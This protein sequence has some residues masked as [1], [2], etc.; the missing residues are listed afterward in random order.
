MTLDA[1]HDIDLVPSGYGRLNR[2]TR[3]I[4]DEA[5]RRDITVEIRDAAR[6]ELV[7]TCAG[8]T[9]TTLESLSEL[10]SA[11]AFRRCDDKRHTRAI[12]ECAGIAVPRG[13]S[14]TFDQRDEG[15]LH[16]RGELVVKPARGEQGWGITVGIRDV[17]HLQRAIASAAAVCPDVLLEERCG[18][19]DLRVIVIGDEVVAAA[20]RRP[21]MVLG[22]GDH[23][24]EELIELE[25]ERRSLATGGSARVPIDPMTL[26]AVRAGGYDLD[27]VLPRDVELMI[28]F[29][30][31]VHSGGTIHDVTDELHPT[32]CEVAIRAAHAIEIPVVGLDLLVG[33]VT[34][35]EYVMIEANEQPGLA[36]HEPRPTAAR[37]IDLLFPETRATR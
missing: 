28:R 11:V 35:P 21:P 15:F 3:I 8:R 29:N 16:E 7:M 27:D 2:Y 31:N 24:V 14:A 23:T 17:G 19:D 22:T 36:N 4:V 6:G 18:G 10:T 26:D 32:L 37:F 34:R 1:S 13:R 25:S 5:L 12:L 30:A 9:V 20:V 33:S